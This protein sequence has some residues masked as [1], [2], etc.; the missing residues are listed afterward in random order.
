MIVDEPSGALLSSI[1]LGV[2]LR[3]KIDNIAHS[4]GPFIIVF[5]AFMVGL[6]INFSIAYF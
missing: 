6:K 4:I 3:G 2:L 5:V 1:I